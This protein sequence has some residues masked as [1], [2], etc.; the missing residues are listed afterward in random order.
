MQVQDKSILNS[1]KFI[2]FELI[3]FSH[4][5]YYCERFTESKFDVKVSQYS[6]I[7]NLVGTCFQKQ[8]NVWNKT[9]EI[10]LIAKD[11]RAQNK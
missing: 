4:E 2:V 8:L 1:P 6:E 7:N 11:H 5:I 9:F 10:K 3:K